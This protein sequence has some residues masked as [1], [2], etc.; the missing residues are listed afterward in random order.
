[1][2]D[3]EILKEGEPETRENQARMTEE[4]EFKIRPTV[5]ALV[6]EM[7]AVNLNNIHARLRQDNEDW[8]WSRS[9]LYRA[10]HR[11]GFKFSS[12]RCGYYERLR[13]DP[14]N[15]ALRTVY[16]Q[17]YLSHLAEHRPIVYMDESWINKNAVLGRIWHDGTAETEDL[18]PAGK[19]TRWILIGAGSKDGWI[20]NSFRMW[21]GNII[22]EDYHSEMNGEVFQDW[23]FKYLLPNVAPNSVLVFDRARYHLE[24][25]KESNGAS[26]QWSKDR[27]IDWLLSRN[28]K[29]EDGHVFSRG[30]MSSLNKS[31]LWALCQIHRPANRFK[32]YDWIADWNSSHGTDI[33]I[34]ILPVAHPQLNPVELI[35]NWIK[36]YVKSNN[37]DY[38]MRTLE[39]LT[40]TRV[41]ELD[42]EWW[43]KACQKSHEFAL[44]Y[45]E[46]D[47]MVSN[48]DGDL[49]EKD[50]VENQIDH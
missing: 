9:S 42:R 15:I 19:G 16:I 12:K 49:F 2:H 13:E 48:E 23:L 17:R 44:G 33:R 4:D 8:T 34:N 36:V 40:K 11:I 35:W 30:E 6:R 46:V 25:T 24:L 39:K 18:V 20:P 5:I 32:V 26:I 14:D 37:H 1:L 43:R 41:A 22:S 50:F 47:E 28:V 38:S 31:Y 3:D 29:C 21:K 45:Q 10:M 27:L 7:V